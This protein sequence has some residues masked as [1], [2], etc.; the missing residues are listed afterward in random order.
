MKKTLFPAAAIAAFALAGCTHP[1]S[2]PP[3]TAPPPT[4]NSPTVSNPSGPT[5]PAAPLKQ[6][7][8]HQATIYTVDLDHGTAANQ[9]LVPQDVPIAHP[10]QPVRDALEELLHAQNSPI[11]AG[12]HLLSVKVSDGLATVDFSHSPVDETQGEDQQAQALEAIQRTLGQFADVSR[13]QILVA[14]QAPA[15]LG[16]AAGG[17]MDVLRPGQTLGDAGGA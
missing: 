16:Q 17:P 13:I 9:Y 8:V 12:T 5:A 14:G 11:P 10:K 1:T 15:S 6:G 3:V 2:S 7:P 4:T